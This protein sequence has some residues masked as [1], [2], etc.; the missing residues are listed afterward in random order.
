MENG[1]FKRFFPESRKIL[2]D[3]IPFYHILNS[4]IKRLVNYKNKKER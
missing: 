2:L 4:E 3:K 1:I